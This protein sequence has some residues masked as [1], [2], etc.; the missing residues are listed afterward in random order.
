MSQLLPKKFYD[1]AH[2]VTIG[3]VG[4]KALAGQHSN[5]ELQITTRIYGGPKIKVTATNVFIALP[6]H[7]LFF[8]LRRFDRFDDY[9][10]SSM[11]RSYHGREILLARLS[12][13]GRLLLNPGRNYI[14]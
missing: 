10:S 14:K 12:E 3:R 9:R 1:M 2:I 5:Q 11:C 7:V 13:E 8:F 4:G 6:G